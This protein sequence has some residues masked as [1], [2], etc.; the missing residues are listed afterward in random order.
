M[1][2]PKEYGVFLPVAN[3][4]WI[5]SKTTPVLD[6]LYAQNRAAAV[7]ARAL[8]LRSHRRSDRRAAASPSSAAADTVLSDDQ[9][10]AL[11]GLLSALEENE[12]EPE[13]RRVIH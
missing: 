4:G 7:A 8:A 10:D 11:D 5:V 1:S 13:L 2:G 12:T 9:S 6:G 3:G